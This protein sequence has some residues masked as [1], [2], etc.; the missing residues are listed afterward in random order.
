MWNGWI[1]KVKISRACGVRG[2]NGEFVQ[3]F[4]LK[5]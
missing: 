3:N 1:K 5:I 2:E 4:D